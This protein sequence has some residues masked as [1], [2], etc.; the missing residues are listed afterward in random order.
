MAKKPIVIPPTLPRVVL[1][2]DGKEYFLVFDFNSICVAEQMTGI[3]LLTSLDFSNVDASKL[4]ALLYASLIKLQPDITLDAAGEL[5]TLRS[6]SKVTKALSDAFTES[7][8][9]PDKDD[10]S[11]NVQKPGSN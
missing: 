5:I 11:K 8:A 10:D 7:H 9:E 3:N 2:I 6:A 1:E 4:R